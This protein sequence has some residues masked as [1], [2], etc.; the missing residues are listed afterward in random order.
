[1]RNKRSKLDGK[2]ITFQLEPLMENEGDEQVMLNVRLDKSLYLAFKF[3]CDETLKISISS[4]VRQI[5]SQAVA[6]SEEL[7]DRQDKDIGRVSS[8]KRVKKK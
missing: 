5:L 3:L 8:V 1:M 7:A 4:A 2:A 6:N